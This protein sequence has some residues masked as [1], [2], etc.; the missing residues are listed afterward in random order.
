MKGI[1]IAPCG[2]PCSSAAPHTSKRLSTRRYFNKQMF[3]TKQPTTNRHTT[4][5]VCYV[6]RLGFIFA[7][8]Y[9]VISTVNTLPDLSLVKG[10]E[11]Y[12]V[13]VYHANIAANPA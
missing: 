3:K 2:L 8:S 6:C 7:S 4:H 9:P 5:R 1:S 11:E 13:R 12:Q 10:E